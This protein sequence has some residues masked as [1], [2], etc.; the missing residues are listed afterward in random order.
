MALTMMLSAQETPAKAAT[1]VNGKN[2]VST[3][4]MNKTTA[5]CKD[6]SSVATPCCKEQQQSANRAQKQA[7][8]PC[9]KDGQ[10]HEGCV[11]SKSGQ[12]KTA[13]CQ[14]HNRGVNKSSECQGKHKEGECCKEKSSAV[15]QKGVVK[16]S[17][18]SNK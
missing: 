3:Q 5:N 18:G 17:K 1:T 8:K 9:C 16:Q 13:E 6:K 15:G 2:Q 4:Q 14:E 11:D 7:D 10:K 12:T